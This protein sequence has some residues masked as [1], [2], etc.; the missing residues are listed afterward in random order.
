MALKKQD[1][2]WGINC[3]LSFV[4]TRTVYRE[5]VTGYNVLCSV[6]RLPFPAKVTCREE[7]QK[8]VAQEIEWLP[9]DAVPTGTRLIVE[10]FCIVT[11]E[12]SR[13]PTS[14]KVESRLLRP[15]VS[16]E[17]STW[18]MLIR[19]KK[20]SNTGRC[21]QHRIVLEEKFLVNVNLKK[22]TD[23]FEAVRNWNGHND[24]SC[25]LK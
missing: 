11:V 9:T 13:S 5:R 8:I 6:Q 23:K 18:R 14:L 21:W 7:N 16:G 12:V 22:R 10:V 3:L 2:L 17:V 4:M 20:V 24:F 1:H 15:S 25:N 19:K